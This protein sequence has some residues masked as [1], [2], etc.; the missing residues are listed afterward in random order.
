M[1][2]G[3]PNSDAVKAL[4][5]LLLLLVLVA[6]PRVA[7][8]SSGDEGALDAATSSLEELHADPQAA[9]GQRVRLRFQ[10]REEC[11]H[12]N[13]LVTRFGAGDYRAFDVWSDRQ[14]LWEKEE[15][16]APIARLFVRRG[17]PAEQ[18]L[19]GARRL[20][21]FEAVVEARQ[22]FL[23]R[24]WLEVESARRV[25][26]E[27]SEGTLLHA[28]RACEAAE[29]LRWAV[30]REGFDQALLGAMPPALRSEL[31]RLREL[32]A[33]PPRDPARHERR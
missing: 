4:A 28:T 18:A 9:L 7:V 13:P 21:R 22:V 6:L 26:D 24:P 27:L 33:Q 12:W 15:W 17:S 8:S 10:L 2:G 16:D 25:G 11:A 5:A 23:G 31:R 19:S 29:Q 30:A 32:A 14:F 1:G 3:A 20:A